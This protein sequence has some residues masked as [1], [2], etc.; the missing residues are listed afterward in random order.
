MCRG[1]CTAALQA[2]AFYLPAIGRRSHFR[3]RAAKERLAGT[4]LI[5]R[6]RLKF[7]LARQASSPSLCASVRAV[8]WA[9]EADQVLSRLAP[10]AC[11]LFADVRI[12][13]TGLPEAPGTD[14]QICVGILRRQEKQAAPVSVPLC[15]QCQGQMRLSYSFLG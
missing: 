13:E 7:E 11:Q 4:P 12:F 5:P 6:L 1:G 9:D 2:S 14:P 10:S 15:E 8:T 3:S